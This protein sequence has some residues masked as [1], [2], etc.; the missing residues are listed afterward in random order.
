MSRRPPLFL[1][2]NLP[3]LIK[4]CKESGYEIEQ[5]SP[6]Q[7]RVYAA[8]AVIDIW[9]ARMKYHRIRGESLNAV[10]RYYSMRARFHRDQVKKLLDTGKTDYYD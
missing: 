3:Q 10:E 1:H 4:L 8:T 7:Y 5:K 2:E 9:P 6:D